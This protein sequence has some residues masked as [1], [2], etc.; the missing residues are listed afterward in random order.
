MDDA[1]LETYW[2]SIPVGKE[3]AITR[4]ELMAKWSMCE[5]SVRGVLH[6]LSH[7]DNGDDYIL[8]RS[9]K[10]KG[11]FKTSDPAEIEAYRK[12]CINKGRSNFAPLRKINRVIANLDANQ[13]S[14][15]NNMRLVRTSLGM[16]QTDVVEQMLVYDP[17]IDCSMLSKMESGKCFPT[18]FQLFLLCRVYGC[19]PGDLVNTEVY[20]TI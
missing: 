9:G 13:F 12:E 5:R 7:Y 10:N 8:I 6:E 2:G 19:E 17:S 1:L 18:P 11:F 4:S 14:M 15:E 20:Q 3:N 16:K